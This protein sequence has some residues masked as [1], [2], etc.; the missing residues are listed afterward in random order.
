MAL[1]LTGINIYP[2]KSARGIA[3]SEWET[4]AF[5]LR[6][7]R[8]WMVVDQTGTFITQRTHPRMALVTV[9]LG[10]GVLQIDAPGMPTLE[11]SLHPAPAVVTQVV[12][13][14]FA[15]QSTWLGEEATLWFT[16]FLGT[17]CSLVHMGD[18][19]VR[20]ANPLF[21]PEATRVSFADGYP[22]LLISEESLADLNARLSHPIPMDRFRPNLVVAGAEAYAEDGWRAIEIGSMALRVV[23]PCFRCAITTT[24]Q[25]T[26]KRGREPLRTLATYRRVGNEVMFGQNVVHQNIGQLRVGDPVTDQRVS[27]GSEQGQ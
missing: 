21:A 13:W 20:R 8:R 11:T 1:S 3:L 6:Y 26:A 27:G 14:N 9:K 7:D 25:V 17:D 15:G 5:G 23:K 10:D 12:V 2:I 4:D 16:E 18:D 24:D 19:V 22:I